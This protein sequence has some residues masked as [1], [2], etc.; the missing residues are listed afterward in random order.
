[1]EMRSFG[2]SP[3][4]AISLIKTVDCPIRFGGCRSLMSIHYGDSWER[5]TYYWDVVTLISILS[6]RECLKSLLPRL[7]AE[8][9]DCDITR[10][11]RSVLSPALAKCS[12]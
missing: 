8:S 12:S 9:M 7:M 5:D 3:C 2:G 6:G 10:A 4:Q 1:M 11:L